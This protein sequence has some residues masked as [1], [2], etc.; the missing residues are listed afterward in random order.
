MFWLGVMQLRSKVTFRTSLRLSL[1]QWRMGRPCRPG[2][3]LHQ[4]S[5]YLPDLIPSFRIWLPGPLVCGSPLVSPVRRTVFHI[6]GP[7]LS[8]L[9][10]HLRCKIPSVNCRCYLYILLL[11]NIVPFSCLFYRWQMSWG[12]GDCVSTAPWTSKH[13]HVGR[14]HCRK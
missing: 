3:P 1:C 5:P 11:F 8:E 6:W 7:L 4:N 2:H 13:P 12:Q 9:P 14:S 10:F